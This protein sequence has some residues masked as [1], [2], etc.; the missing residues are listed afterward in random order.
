M[1]RKDTIYKEAIIFLGAGFS[2]PWIP[3]MST[4][5]NSIEE[6]YGFSEIS[7]AEKNIKYPRYFNFYKI[8]KTIEFNKTSNNI[9]DK[10]N[11]GI[12]N[13]YDKALF[14]YYTKLNSSPLGEYYP[15]WKIIRESSEYIDIE[16]ILMNLNPQQFLNI[17]SHKY[18]DIFS[19]EEKFI[20][21]IIMNGLLRGFEIPDIIKFNNIK[22]EMET[23]YNLFTLEII[24]RLK[25][26]RN[27][28]LEFIKSC[29]AVKLEV[30]Q[31]NKHFE[32]LI[33]L[34]SDFSF[35]VYTTNYD[36]LVESY[37]QNNNIP[38]ELGLEIDPITGI[39]KYDN[40]RL[41]KQ[42]E[43]TRLIKL[44]GSI[45]YY[46]TEN[47]KVVQIDTPD[48]HILPNGEKLTD[49]MIY[50][51]PQKKITHEFFS[52][53]FKYFNEALSHIKVCLVIGF[54]FRDDH[55]NTIFKK[56]INENPNFKVILID[57]LASE[58]QSKRLAFMEK[59]VFPFP[60]KV[61]E[62]KKFQ[63]KIEKYL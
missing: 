21:P 62:I 59:N 60:Y 41:F 52:S 24:K 36:K 5:P 50:P 61:D 16:G 51:L 20:D 31:L 14:I 18:K 34:L 58:I 56:A 22:T 47:N 26:L 43:V 27:K 6:Y 1:R 28:I 38:I 53:Q 7:D 49:I 46:I 2:A 48:A 32:P 11:N 17:L 35:D 39:K 13:D 3:T 23:K 57:P 12:L 63:R 30:N 9:I 44:H 42:N 4:F 55:I 29:C 8:L 40:N 54:S 25:S 37:Y 19:T 10:K 45:D 15:I 33:N